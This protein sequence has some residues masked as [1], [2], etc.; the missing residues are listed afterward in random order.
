MIRIRLGSLPEHLGELLPRGLLEHLRA[1]EIV[2]QCLAALLEDL[3]LVVYEDVVQ[4]R[5]Y[6][7]LFCRIA[8]PKHLLNLVAV[9]LLTCERALQ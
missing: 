3:N 8:V 4:A 9:F 6:P 1:L 2:L 5:G 7:G